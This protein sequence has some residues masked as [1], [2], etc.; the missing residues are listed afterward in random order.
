M[1]Y[2]V[3]IINYKDLIILMKE[4]ADDRERALIN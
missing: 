4:A 1:I 3:C 2:D